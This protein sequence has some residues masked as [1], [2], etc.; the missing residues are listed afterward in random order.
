MDK[1]LAHATEVV[2]QTGEQL[3]AATSPGGGR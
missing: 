2:D 1:G 3:P